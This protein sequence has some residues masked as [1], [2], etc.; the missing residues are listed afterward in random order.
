VLALDADFL[1]LDSPTPL[2]TKQF[3]KRRHIASEEDFE[4]LNRLYMVEGQFS[5]TGMNADH[6]LRVK[7]SEVKQFAVDLA[8]ALGAVPGLNVVGGGDRRA[9]FLA[10]VVK[11][12]KSAGGESVSS[13]RAAAAGDGA[14]DRGDDQSIARQRGGDVHESRRG[15]SGV[16]AL[17]TLTTEMAAGQVSTLFVLGGN[18]VYNRAGDLQFMA[19]FSESRQFRAPGEEEDE[20]AASAKWHV[21]QAHFLEQWSDARA[22][23]G[24][25]SIQQ[26]LI[27]C[28]YGRQDAGRDGR[29]GDRRAG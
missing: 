7:P 3:S 20:T 29:A 12:L 13:R 28:M 9:K 10:A 15:H 25:V 22:I 5:I 14:R 8:A 17:K 2:P 21:P 1:G 27:D 6:R 19:A 16:D 11:D 18:P 24:T 23:D 26:P 4:K